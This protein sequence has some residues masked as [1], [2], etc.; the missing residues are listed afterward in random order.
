[1]KH[2]VEYYMAVLFL[3]VLMGM[4]FTGSYSAAENQG[5]S[6]ECVQV[7]HL[8]ESTYALSYNQE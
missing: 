3:V 6:L 1:M 5:A 8:Q 4:Y 2:F 7:S